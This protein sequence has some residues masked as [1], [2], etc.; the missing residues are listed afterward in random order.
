MKVKNVDIENHLGKIDLLFISSGF[1]E[2]SKSLSFKLNKTKIVNTVLF[3]LEDNYTLAVNNKEEMVSKFN[4]EN[5]IE[6]PK[7]DSFSTFYLFYEKIDALL[8]TISKKGRLKVVLDVTAFSREILLV[9]LKVLSG[10]T[11]IKKLDITFV[12]TP[13]EN[14]SEGDGFWLTK[15]VR[16]IRSIFGYSGSMTP[17]KKLLLVVF[18]GFEEERT[19]IIVE[20]FEP[21][22]L[23]L[24]NPSKSGS[25][26]PELKSFG[27]LK[28]RN[29]KSKFNNILIEEKEFSCIEIDAT[30]KLLDEIYQEYN[31]K[32]NIAISPL[33]NKISTIAIALASILNETFQVCYASANQYN[34][35][36]Q[37]T[38]CDYFLVYNLSD[39]FKKE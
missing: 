3:H 38:P 24:A 18:N 17:S 15:G 31:E 35:N 14:Y 25:I 16:E 30:I 12:H 33:N 7:N 23:I 9:L 27:D 26:N 2:R 29:I 11:F 19:E 4:I 10:P 39:Y 34:I 20:S 8:G 28:Y 5:I 37:L 21:N 13:V 22:A 1:E 6:Y 32:Y 36:K